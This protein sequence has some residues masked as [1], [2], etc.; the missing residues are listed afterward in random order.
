MKAQDHYCN[1]YDLQ[2]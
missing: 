2:R 1:K